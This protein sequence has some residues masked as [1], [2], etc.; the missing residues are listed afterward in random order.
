MFLCLKLLELIP[1]LDITRRRRK[2]RE[3]KR[4]TGTEKAEARGAKRPPWAAT[5]MTVT[6]TKVSD[7]IKG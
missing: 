2:K 5:M 7:W 1:F 3:A 6:R 4:G